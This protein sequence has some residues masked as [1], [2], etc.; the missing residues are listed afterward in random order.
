MSAI[1]VAEKEKGRAEARPNTTG[2]SMTIPAGHP[3]PESFTPLYLAPLELQHG[4][5]SW[6]RC[7]QIHPGGWFKDSVQADLNYGLVRRETGEKAISLW[8]QRVLQSSD[9][10]S[11]A[12]P[13]LLSAGNAQLGL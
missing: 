10:A 5:H 1:T 3:T 13:S 11:H 6:R 7:G 2:L 8:C 4:S 9:P 12:K